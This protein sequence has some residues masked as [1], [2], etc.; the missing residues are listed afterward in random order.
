MLVPMEN[1]MKKPFITHLIVLFS[2]C[3]ICIASSLCYSWIIGE[4]R[5]INSDFENDIV[6]QKPKEWAL[7]KGG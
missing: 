3:L 1:K 5:L 7:E 4:N 2:L 6:G